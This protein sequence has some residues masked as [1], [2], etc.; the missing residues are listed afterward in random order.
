VPLLLAAR[1]DLI[2]DRMNPTLINIARSFSQA[3]LAIALAVS[4][5]R[6]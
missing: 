6:I 5:T 4:R 1:H 2:H 3:L